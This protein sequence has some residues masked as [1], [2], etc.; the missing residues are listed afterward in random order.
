MVGFKPADLDEWA[1]AR[2]G[3]A[4]EFVAIG[5]GTRGKDLTNFCGG[6]NGLLCW[7]SSIGD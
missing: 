5:V 6:L 3:Y 2:N 7:V 1:V 4:R